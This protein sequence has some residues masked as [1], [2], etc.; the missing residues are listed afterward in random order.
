MDTAPAPASCDDL[1]RRGAFGRERPVVCAL[2]DRPCGD[3]R[4]SARQVAVIAHGVTLRVD[5]PLCVGCSDELSDDAD[6]LAMEAL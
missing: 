1:D 4:A 2:C 3:R 5:D 6:R